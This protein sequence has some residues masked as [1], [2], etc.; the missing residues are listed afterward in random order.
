MDDLNKVIERKAAWI[1]DGGGIGLP[2]ADLDEIL[3]H[4]QW[5]YKKIATFHGREQLMEAALTKY[6]NSKPCEK[7]GVN[8]V[9]IGQSGAGKTA[10]MAKLASL[11]ADK[12]KETEEASRKPVLIR[13]CGT[14]EGSRTGFALI[15]SICRQIEFAHGLP[16]VP[17]AD[18]AKTTEYLHKLLREHPVVLFIDSLDQLTNENEA[19]S[20][21]SFLKKRADEDDEEV[22][23]EESETSSKSS[24]RSIIVVSTL[25]D[26][27]SS[28]DDSGFYGCATHLQSVKAPTLE[29]PLLAA[30][31]ESF[32]QNAL[33]ESGRSVTA[34]QLQHIL[35]QGNAEPSPLY[36]TLASRFF[37]KWTSALP[38][39]DLKLVPTVRALI[40]QIFAQVENDYGTVLVSRALAYLTFSKNGLS[41]TEW[42]DLLSLDD[43]VVDAV[44]QYSEMNIRRVPTHV[45]V[46]LKNELGDLLVSR[47]G[48][49]YYW[50]HRQLIEAAFDVYAPFKLRAH[51]LMGT[52]FADLVPI[53]MIMSRNVTKQPR[54]IAAR[55]EHSIWL[56]SA[57]I[58][59]SRAGEGAHHLVEVARMLHEEGKAG[60][61]QDT[62]KRSEEATMR[63][64][65]E[66]C[67][68]ECVIAAF[69]TSSEVGM[70]LV[71]LVLCLYSVKESLCEESENTKVLGDR[72]YAFY[73]WLLMDAS[74]MATATSH[75]KTLLSAIF[76]SAHR[77]PKQSALNPQMRDLDGVLTAKS[78]VSFAS[79]NQK[80]NDN[81]VLIK[82]RDIGTASEFSANVMSLAGHTRGVKSV[83]YSPDGK[84]IVSGSWDKTIKVWDAASGACVATLEGHSFLVQSVSYSPDGKQ[85]VSGSEDN[86]IKVWDAASGACVSTLEGHTGDVYS[87]SYSPDGKQI[88]S[89]SSD[90]TIKVW[91]IFAFKG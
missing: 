5:A 48:G 11:V 21:L 57:K 33:Q 56:P 86:T 4:Y 47:S 49:R 45:V 71:P 17:R 55:D 67:S 46:R 69:R 89:G 83:S 35:T 15:K 36:F 81:D 34:D 60:G 70:S 41:L 52:Y 10:F 79:L 3:H 65:E 59:E 6:T 62:K 72:L 20:S 32:L 91:D 85:I 31:S 61:G 77:Q 16:H 74:T 51:E 37:M 64:I 66:I 12:E 19:R 28:D 53:Q 30:D 23:G 9:C 39:S 50:Y 80:Q 63:A 73:R 43:E 14:S 87:V 2:G 40:C 88:A 13:F 22:E 18:Y 84:Q 1:K 8:L 29:V 24:K 78:S 90:A 26:D 54:V 75:L 76:N 38:T 82:C 44:F 58:N 42:E 27:T 68:L 7:Y 25:P